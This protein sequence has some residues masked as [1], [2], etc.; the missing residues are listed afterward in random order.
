V[1]KKF[2]KKRKYIFKPNIELNKFFT[3]YNPDLVVVPTQGDDVGYY[4][5]SIFAINTK[6]KL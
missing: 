4:Y 2:F 6:L 5:L 3:N 1:Y